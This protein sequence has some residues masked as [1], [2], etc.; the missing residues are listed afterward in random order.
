MSLVASCSRRLRVTS[1]PVAFGIIMSST[2]EI[3]KTSRRERQRFCAV[4]RGDDV[5]ARALETERHKGAD[6]LFVVCNEHERCS[7][8]PSSEQSQSHGL[9]DGLRARRR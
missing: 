1:S 7:L 5:V 3:G 9:G 6:V 8:G 2:I 4:G